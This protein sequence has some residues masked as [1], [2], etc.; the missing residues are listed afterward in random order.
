MLK[1]CIDVCLLLPGIVTFAQKKV[2]P[3]PA[4]LFKEQAI[5]DIQSQYDVYK[6]TALQIW[7]YAELGYKE[8][9]S[10][11]LLQKIL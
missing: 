9:K 3:S 7:D 4:D 6:N 5:S 10:S 1:K 8:N 11:A 2:K